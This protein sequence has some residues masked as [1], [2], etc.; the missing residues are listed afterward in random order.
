MESFTSISSLH[1]PSTHHHLTLNRLPFRIVSASAPATYTL[2]Q[3]RVFTTHDGC[4]LPV[5]YVPFYWFCIPIVWCWCSVY[6]TPN[7]L[8]TLVHIF[9]FYSSLA[10]TI[11]SFAA[12]QPINGGKNRLLKLLFQ[13]ASDVW[14]VC[15]AAIEIHF[16]VRW[17]R[18][19]SSRLSMFVHV[20]CKPFMYSICIWYRPRYR[21]SILMC[22]LS[23][24]L[25]SREYQKSNCAQFESN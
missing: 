11:H 3:C 19:M 20:K 6:V 8:K 21:N 2:L 9:P 22:Q 24:G 7:E 17:K 16:F 18:Y 1:F 14:G 12:R 5:V 10:K 15:A 25:R 23:V 13:R 4:L